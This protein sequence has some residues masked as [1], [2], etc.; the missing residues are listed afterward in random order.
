LCGQGKELEI[1]SYQDF[2]PSSRWPTPQ[3]GRTILEPIR[4]NEEAK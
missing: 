3:E 1:K 2:Q 4:E